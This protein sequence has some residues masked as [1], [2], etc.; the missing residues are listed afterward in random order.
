MKK[1]IIFIVIL[2]VAVGLA[3]FYYYQK[4]IYSKETL[5]LEILGPNEAD[6][7]QEIEYVVRFKNNGDTSLEQPELVFEYPEYSV[8]TTDKTLLIKKSSEELGGVIYPGEEKSFRFKARLLGKEGDAKEAKVSLS[9]QP[10]NIKAR[11]K[12]ETTITTVIKKVSLTFDFDLPTKADAGR[13]LIFRLNYFS[14]VDYPIPNLKVTVNYPSNFEFI[15]SSPKALEKTEWDIGLLN[16]ASGGRIEI[17]GRLKGEVGEEKIFQAKIGSWQNGEFILL[18]E[19]NRGVTINNPSTYVS[20]QINGSPKYVA[21]PGDLLHYQIFFK[22]VGYEQL[23]NLFL[24]AKLEGE[25]FD[26][27]TIQSPMGE[28]RQGDNSIVFNW[29]QNP[30]LQFLSPDQQGEV[31]FWI[32]LKNEWPISDASGKNPL[33]KNTLYLSQSKEEFINKVNSRL[34]ISQKGY[35]NDEIFGN[36]GSLPPKVGGEPTTYTIVWQVKNYY[37]NVNNVKVKAVLPAYCALTGLIFPE[38]QSSKFTFDSQS[39]E[40]V[41]SVGDLKASQGVFGTAAPNISFQIKFTPTGSQIG[42]MPEIIG[43]AKMTGEDQW[44]GETIE[45]TSSGVTTDLPEDKLI[46]DDKK[47]VM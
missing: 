13:D 38:E 23:T 47:T 29:D 16:K 32:K 25:S 11:Y 14:N 21:N 20:Q 27:S 44:T 15:E 37:N 3:G 2:A 4:N 36:T 8:P 34:V 43:Q 33:I 40:I 42:Q 24:I 41:W 30:S 6:L 39:R 18:K 7:L 17:K 1:R 19:I 9:Y 22:N 45:G 31:D 12:S 5:R 10:K 28:F 26:F 35:F 46:T